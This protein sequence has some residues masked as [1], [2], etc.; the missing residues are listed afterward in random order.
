[1]KN[2]QTLTEH[3]SI[4]PFPFLSA[5]R[6]DLLTHHVGQFRRNIQIEKPH[7]ALEPFLRMLNEFLVS[8][9][10]HHIGV[11]AR[12]VFLGLLRTLHPLLGNDLPD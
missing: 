10:Q 11:N 8:Q 9:P 12:E 6:I 3:S 1:M 2:R 5:V 7:Q 4:E